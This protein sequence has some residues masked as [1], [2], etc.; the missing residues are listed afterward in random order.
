[1]DQM[2]GWHELSLDDYE[3]RTRAVFLSKLAQEFEAWQRKRIEKDKIWLASILK[4]AWK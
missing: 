2:D 4:K 1:M 3:R